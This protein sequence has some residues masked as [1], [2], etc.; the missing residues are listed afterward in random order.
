ML[1]DMTDVDSTVCDDL[2]V[3]LEQIDPRFRGVGHLVGRDRFARISAASICVVGLGGVG[4]W[5]V[6]ALARSGVG[7]L[8][9]IDLDEVCVTNINRQLQALTDTVGRS[10]ADLLAARIEAI[11]PNCKVTAVK[12]FFTAQSA[13]QILSERFDL[14]IDTIDSNEHK[15]TLIG[16]CVKRSQ[17]VL[18]V[19]SGGDRL[20]CLS[21]TVA[22]LA[23]TI[24]DPLLQIVRKNLRQQYGFPKGE[25]A[26]FGVPC[27]YIP[28]Q[29]GARDS[30]PDGGG[31]ETKRSRRSCNDG[32]GSA[33]FVTGALGFIAAGEA[34]KMLCSQAPNP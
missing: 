27:V 18:T 3:G 34:I 24:H 5:C 15:T 13:D 10:K 1:L 32:L 20:D 30:S 4:S 25:R 28:K 9:L 17:P 16:E 14:V 29:R 12:R 26:R 8:T 22:D 21:A 6:E 2:D 19:G 31:A 33:A 7:R 23:R 11:N